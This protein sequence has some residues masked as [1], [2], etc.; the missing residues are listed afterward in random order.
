PTTTSSTSLRFPP[1]AEP[2]PARTR[3]ATRPLP[4]RPGAP[5]PPS[6]RSVRGRSAP[7]PLF[8]RGPGTCLSPPPPRVWFGFAP[9]RFVARLGLEPRLI[10]FSL[11]L[12]SPVRN[13]AWFDLARPRRRPFGVASGSI[14]LLLAAVV[15]VGSRPVRFCSSSPSSA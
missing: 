11:V 2:S 14:L 13:C 5:F 6:P 10:W 9:P 1:P 4:R 7:P 12:D 8:V 15:R 3:P